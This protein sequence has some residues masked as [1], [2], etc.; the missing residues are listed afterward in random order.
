M[1]V[2]AISDKP[3]DGSDEQSIRKILDNRDFNRIQMQI[4]LFEDQSRIIFLQCSNDTENS[5]LWANLLV[6]IVNEDFK[7]PL[8]EGKLFFTQKNLEKRKESWSAGLVALPARFNIGHEDA[9]QRALRRL[10]RD[11]QQSLSEEEAAAQDTHDAIMNQ[12]IDNIRGYDY[13]IRAKRNTTVRAPLITWSGPTELP[14]GS[15]ILWHGFHTTRG[16]KDAVAPES[17]AFLDYTSGTVF[18]D[19]QKEAYIHN[20][21]RGPFDAGSGTINTRSARPNVEYNSAKGIPQRLIPDGQSLPALMGGD[22]K[23]FN[24]CGRIDS[25]DVHTLFEKGYG[26]IVPVVEGDVKLGEACEQNG[27]GRWTMTQ[28]EFDQYSSLLHNTTIE[29]ENFLTYIIFER[30]MLFL[31]RWLSVSGPMSLRPVFVKLWDAIF[32]KKSVTFWEGEVFQYPAVKSAVQVYLREHKTQVADIVASLGTKTARKSAAKPSTARKRKAASQPVDEKRATKKIKTSD[33]REDKKVDHSTNNDEKKKTT[34]RKPTQTYLHEEDLQP[35]LVPLFQLRAWYML[36][37]NGLCLKL[38]PHAQTQKQQMCWNA[39]F[40]TRKRSQTDL[41]WEV[42][43]QRH[44]LYW[45]Q[46]MGNQK[47][48]MA[49]GD[50]LASLKAYFESKVPES[51]DPSGIDP[52]VY[53]RHRRGAQGGGN[54]LAADSGMGGATSFFTGKNHVALQTGKFGATLASL[55]YKSPL[56][57]FERFRVKTH[58]SWGLGHVDH[59]VASRLQ[60]KRQTLESKHTAQST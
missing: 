34:L 41:A 29:F 55:F 4:P 15:V 37:E 49:T 57:V 25:V 9:A 50:T 13:V 60:Y 31:T 52:F 48:G 17:T 42:F 27:Y 20:M 53:H 46:H 43:G 14:Y 21:S 28:E 11:E 32:Q 33:S 18:S 19:S 7:N 1:E 45:R 8:S 51:S 12:H 58:G 26:V 54:K 2:K 3:M 6:F 16:N 22:A 23:S 35:A 10:M 24:T 38:S 59:R 39:I 56:V 36:A 5:Q 30:E 47:G 44:L 40:G